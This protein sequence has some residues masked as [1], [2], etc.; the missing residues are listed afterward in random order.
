MA[1]TIAPD[2]APILSRERS[3]STGPKRSGAA[4]VWL[5]VTAVI[6]LVG[7]GLFRLAAK[8]AASERRVKVVAAGKD[9]P[10][11]VRLGF[12]SL[13]YVDIPERYVTGDMQVSYEKLVGRVTRTFIPQGEPL[14]DADLFA[15]GRNLGLSIDTALRAITLDLAEDAL[16]DHALNAGDYVDVLV[17]SSSRDGKKFTKTVCQQVEVLLSVP[18][19]AVLSHNMRAVEQNRVT[20]AVT[21]AQAEDLAEA[22]EVGKIRLTLRNRLSRSERSLPGSSPADILP[23]SALVGDVPPAQALAAAPP[24]PPPPAMA[25]PPPALASNEGEAAKAPLQWVVEVFSGSKKE[26]YAF[27]QPASN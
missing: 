20:L 12:T 14:R 6:V 15:P 26:T 7:A 9:L 22:A 4:F 21:P 8:P 24:L 11:G 1:P 2:V 27:P 3:V 17:T 19:E 16:V 18:R 10:P 5:V 23:S 13:H 25:P